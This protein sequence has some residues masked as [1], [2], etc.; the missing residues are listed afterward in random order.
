MAK[1]MDKKYAW[2]SYYDEHKAAADR[3]L[4]CEPSDSAQILGL[5]DPVSLQ[6]VYKAFDKL[7]NLL[8]PESS[9]GNP[10]YELAQEAHDRTYS[11]RLYTTILTEFQ[12][13][14]RQLDLTMPI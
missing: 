13:Y 5:E 14:G 1:N 10:Q 7:S 9:K 6:D 2:Q 4:S 11:I 3:I 12:G 8:S